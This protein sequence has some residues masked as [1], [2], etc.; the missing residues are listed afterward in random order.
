[1]DKPLK[2]G[3]KMNQNKKNSIL[4]KPELPIF[5]TIIIILIGVLPILIEKGKKIAL[6]E[7]VITYEISEDLERKLSVS[8]ENS[9]LSISN[10]NA[11]EFKVIKKVGVIVTAYSSSPWE[12]DGS[13]YITAAGTPTRDGV[14]ANNYLP[15][16]TKVKIP[17]IYGDKVFVVEDRMSWKKGNYQIDIWLPSYWEAKSFG[18]KRTY[19]EILES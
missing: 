7:K 18:A 14:I 2:R 10:P 19:I 6:A 11:P 17:E 5:L 12:T 8:Q 13:P 4:L 16:G 15:L 3:F 9:L 1:M